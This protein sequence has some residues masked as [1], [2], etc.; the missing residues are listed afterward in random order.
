MTNVDSV[1]SSKEVDKLHSKNISL[2]RIESRKL[3]TVDFPGQG[4]V[5][6]SPKTMSLT[7][8]RKRTSPG[9]AHDSAC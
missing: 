8:K 9:H 6:M 1:V 3:L 5:W 7:F 2:H 4:N